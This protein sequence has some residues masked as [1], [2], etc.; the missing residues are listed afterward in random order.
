VASYAASLHA[1]LDL[2]PR[3]GAGRSRVA[4]MPKRSSRGALS[5]S[6]LMRCA[7]SLRRH[8]IRLARAELDA[9]ERDRLAT[10][11]QVLVSYWSQEGDSDQAGR[12]QRAARRVRRPREPQ[13]AEAARAS[14]RPDELRPV[15]LDK[16]P[17]GAGNNPYDA[18][19]FDVLR[20]QP[21]DDDAAIKRV[22]AQ[23]TRA[24]TMQTDDPTTVAP[25]SNGASQDPRVAQRQ[26]EDHTLRL[27][28]DLMRLASD[29]LAR[30]GEP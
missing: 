2:D 12:A 28:Y 14:E 29:T 19:P 18:N 23:M 1:V 6:R 11:F 13:A 16:N 5:A 3:D 15:A 9:E 26:L 7:R 22:A 24:A 10:A 30:G 20:V 25:P 27:T 17:F 8:A 21:S 4:R